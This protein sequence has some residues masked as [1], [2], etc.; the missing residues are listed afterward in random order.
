MI[1]SGRQKKPAFTS[2]KLGAFVSL[3]AS[4]IGTVSLAWNRK[5]GLFPVEDGVR[6]LYPAGRNATTRDVAEVY[7]PSVFAFLARN[8]ERYLAE[9]LDFMH[10]E[11][12]SVCTDWRV[13]YVENDSGDNTREILS[14]FASKHIGRVH[15]EHLSLSA[16][17]STDLC[18]RNK[19]NCLAR[20]ELLGSLRNRL[21]KKALSWN[22]SKLLIMIDTD[23][24]RFD[25]LVFWRM[26]TDVLHPRQADGVF[27][28][29]KFSSAVG[30]SCIFQPF[31][32]QIYDYGAIIP[33]DLLQ[34]ILALNKTGTYFPVQSA[35]SGFGIYD[36]GA[37]RFHKPDYLRGDVSHQLEVIGDDPHQ[38]QSWGLI[39]HISFNLCLPRLY[40]Y[41][42]F[43]PEYG[44]V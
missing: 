32:C 15:G 39:E 11:L 1:H 29:S 26:Y 36:M 28:L 27:G 18:P 43:Q 40:I 19:L 20:T 41:P 3:F 44:G 35:F 21:V 7:P 25:P 34:D 22:E 12:F 24:F 8:G 13:I 38:R 33:V 4:S 17:H 2:R 42:D 10:R 14:N 23:F 30:N 5:R 9:N 31:G 37:I 6:R 16:K